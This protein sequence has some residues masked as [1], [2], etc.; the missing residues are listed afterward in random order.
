MLR[1]L[2]WVTDVQPDP[3]QKMSSPLK[4]PL[5]PFSVEHDAECH[6]ITKL[7]CWWESPAWLCPVPAHWVPTQVMERQSETRGRPWCCAT[8]AQQKPEREW[9]TSTVMGTKSKPQ[10]HMNYYE[11]NYCRL[12]RNFPATCIHSTDEMRLVNKGV[13]ATLNILACLNI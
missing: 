6:G 12:S 10:Q 4:P 7:L 13:Q 3:N 5:F 1:S 11:E 8:T 2:L 9:A